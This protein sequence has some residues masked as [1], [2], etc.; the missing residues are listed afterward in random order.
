MWR[1]VTGMSQRMCQHHWFLRGTAVRRC[2]CGLTA[3]SSLSTW[4]LNL[5]Y[6]FS[7]SQ[8]SFLN[9]HA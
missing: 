5:A 9:P 4:T 6:G 7:L 3:M 8:L 1:L 2:K